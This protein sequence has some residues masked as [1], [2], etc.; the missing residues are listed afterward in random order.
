MKTPGLLTIVL[1]A[2]AG[3]VGCTT[4]PRPSASTAA[5]VVFSP[6]DQTVVR[7]TLAELANTWNNHDMKGMHELFTED[8]IWIRH[9]GNTWR[10]KSRIFVNHE[11]DASTPSLSIERVE[12]RCVAPQVAVAVATMKYGEVSLPSGQT[13]AGWHNRATFV[14][15]KSGEAWKIVHLHKSNLNPMVEQNETIPEQ[16]K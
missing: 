6:E 3:L 2:V 7:A 15:V 4:T 12:V 8:A 5:S 11:F 10:G 9:S 16:S 13:N 14:L 1:V